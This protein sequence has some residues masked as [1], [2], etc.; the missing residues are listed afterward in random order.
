M[1]IDLHVHTSERSGCAIAGS[2]E[3]LRAAELGGLDAIAVTDHGRLVP[4][5][6]RR[7]WR[8]RHPFLH[9]LPGIEITLEEDVLVI[10]LD[11]PQ[12]E[13]W[14]WTWPALHDHVRAR[15]GL[16]I[17]AHPLRYAEEIRL[18]LDSF[19]PDALE[20]WSTNI[21]PRKV[22]A[23]RAEADRLGLPVVANSDAHA[24]TPLGRFC[25]RLDEPAVTDAEILAAIREG[26]FTPEAPALR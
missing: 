8:E 18:D 7:R 22:A 3:Q 12:L 5:A 6:E 25:S 15:G 14:D 4:V 17:V 10:G 26:R 16:L 9:V 13:R 24:P 11:D 21:P 2:E 20:A 1:R 23:I 19:P